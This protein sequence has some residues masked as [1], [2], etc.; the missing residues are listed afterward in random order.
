MHRAFLRLLEG[1]AGLVEPL[2][3]CLP[4]AKPSQGCTSNCVCFSARSVCAD[5]L[6]AVVK[7]MQNDQQNTPVRA[8]ARAFGPLLRVTLSVLAQAKAVWMPAQPSVMTFVLSCALAAGAGVIDGLMTGDV[9]FKPEHCFPF[10]L[11]LATRTVVGNVTAS[12]A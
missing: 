11:T 9:T 3:P 6:D 8:R 7:Q 12:P 4:C 1:E 10:N 2:P 5:L